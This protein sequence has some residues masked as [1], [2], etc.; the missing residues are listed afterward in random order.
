MAARDEKY[1]TVETTKVSIIFVRVDALTNLN[2]KISWTMGGA[3]TKPSPAAVREPVIAIAIIEVINGMI[4]I[5]MKNNKYKYIRFLVCSVYIML[6]SV[7][8]LCTYND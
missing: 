4:I 6:F 1:T 7:I 8:S 3:I 5:V 2:E